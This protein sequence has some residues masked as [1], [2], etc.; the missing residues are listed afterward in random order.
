M[1]TYQRLAARAGLP[2]WMLI[3]QLAVAQETPTEEKPAEP[4]KTEEPATPEKPETRTGHDSKHDLALLLDRVVMQTK[5]NNQIMEKQLSGS[6]SFSQQKKR[7][8]Q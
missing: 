8:I 4:E 7:R 2:A 1:M 5:K 3:S 6:S